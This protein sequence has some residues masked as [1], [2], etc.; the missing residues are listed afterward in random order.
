MGEKFGGEL[1]D[2]QEEISQKLDNEWL[3]TLFNYM[4]YQGEEKQ[5]ERIETAQSYMLNIIKYLCEMLYYR[6]NENEKSSF[7]W[8]KVHFGHF[9]EKLE[10]S[11][12][13]KKGSST[14]QNAHSMYKIFDK[15][16]LEIL[17]Y[18]FDNFR[19]IQS[20]TA[21][22]F[23]SFTATIGESVGDKVCIFDKKDTK[24]PMKLQAEKS[25]LLQWCKIQDYQIKSKLEN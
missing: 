3:E 13:T 25:F 15:E 7:D 1:K 19:A 10:S 20:E 23:R 18:V 16:A 2:K 6:A 17:I 5:M 9:D 14:T 8:D 11:S 21:E 4:K 24:I 22:V 12:P